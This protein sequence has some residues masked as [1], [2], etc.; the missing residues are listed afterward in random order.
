ME[1]DGWNRDRT[2]TPGTG[3]VYALLVGID[4]YHPTV[5]AR[6]LKG[7]LN[8]ITAA[9]AWLADRV[10]APLSPLELCDGKATVAAI[11]DAITGHLG[12]AGPG[13]TV[14][15]WFSGHGTRFAVRGPEEL[16]KEGTGHYQAIVCADGPLAD[17]ELG[18]LLESVAA[19]GAHT[20]AV[21]DCCYSGGTTRDDEFGPT[22]RFVP[23]APEWRLPAPAP[24][25]AAG[26][27]GAGTREG[28]GTEP[29]GAGHV[30]LAASTVDQVAYEDDL[31]GRRHGMF[32]HA[33]LEAL[34]TAG[35]TATSRE[36]LA[37]AH[38]R[39]QLLTSL[40]HPLVIPHDAGGLADRPF[41]GGTARE[42]SPQ[43]LR[44]GREGWE[45]DHG[46]LHGLSGWA[47]GLSAGD[48]GGAA[49]DDGR[50]AGDGATAFVV[51]S[52]GPESGIRQVYVREVR[53][54]RALVTPADWTP[55]PARV[56]PVAVSA[57]A[58]PPARVLVDA[59]HEP[60]AE[61]WLCA[62][63]ATAGPGGG[64]TPLL[65]AGPATRPGLA[66]GS[67]L[68]PRQPEPPIR[69]RVVVRDGRADVTHRDGTVAVP[70][71][72]LAD[73]GDAFDVVACLIHLTRWYQLHGLRNMSSPLA[74]KVRIE[75]SDAYGSS[76]PAAA[77]SPYG[78]QV[79]RYGGGPGHWR[80]PQVHVRIHNR[81]DRPLWAL[82]LDLTDS[83]AADP[84]LY[85]PDFIGPGLTG[86]ALDGAPVHLRLPADRP[87]RPG[88][89]V[90]DWLKLVVAEHEFNT[91]P[92][93]L[94]RLVPKAKAGR[95]R[96][97]PAAAD[98][99]LR[100]TAPTA[101]H[102]EAGPGDRPRGGQWATDTLAL[103][104]VVPG[105]SGE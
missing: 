35:P 78:E 5:A 76:S 99:M 54:D 20:T 59:P 36:I 60:R 93:Q 58:L 6:P 53:P 92:F 95:A 87:L 33:L 103:R 100:F 27:A 83:H 22:A 15:F 38:C 28:A 3:T 71:L 86:Y 16:M 48:D 79:F 47:D 82:L 17:T 67:G 39:V 40:Q 80:E 25:T 61:S 85:R 105:G 72:P 14:L 74:G 4:A 98:G 29:Y 41:L 56:Y 32:S 49:D 23:P 89:Y 10:D 43:L 44:H 102:R 2:R 57:L 30:T 24:G 12:K 101:G 52:G 51:T 55:D 90:R 75:V 73:R 45:V 13:D 77:D 84:G 65:R 21:M 7:C 19:R 34:G 94:E 64:P 46:S 26:T 91:V 50:P 97:E 69:F 37:A 96:L 70:G 62:A 31:G 88:A 11:R 18:S 63:L 68:G 1:A 8:D 104:T 42:P 9:R 66:T 81:S